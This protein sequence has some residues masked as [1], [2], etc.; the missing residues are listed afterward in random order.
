M[1]AKFKTPE[2]ERE[3]VITVSERE[4]HWLK[5]LIGNGDPDSSN[6]TATEDNLAPRLSWDRQYD[7]YETLYRL[8]GDSCEF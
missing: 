3:V 4:A 1:K 5:E 8:L 2:V 7:F 6:E